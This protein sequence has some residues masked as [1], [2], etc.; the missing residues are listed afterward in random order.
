MREQRDAPEV[1]AVRPVTLLVQYLDGGVLQ[2]LRHLSPVP[3]FY[4]DGTETLR[5][6]GLIVAVDTHLKIMVYITGRIRRML[7]PVSR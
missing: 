7:P 6:N 4:E 2:L 3:H 1:V 5:D